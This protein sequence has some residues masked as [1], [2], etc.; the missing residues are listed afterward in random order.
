[1]RR[2]PLLR[3]SW[4]SQRSDLV[5]DLF[6]GGGGASTGIARALGRPVD[7]AINHDGAALAMHAANHPE[8]RHYQEDIWA[9]D[10]R[11][12]CGSRRVAVLWASPDCTSHSRAK[13]KKPR[14]QGKRVL[15]D[16][17]LRWAREV[18]PRRIFL[19]N[20]EEW[21][22]W[23]PLDAEGYP[24]KAQEGE[25]FRAWLA[26]LIDLGYGV[27]FRTLVAADYGAPTT[28]KRLYLVATLDG[29]PIVWSGASHGRGLT[30]W[31]PA[32]DIIDWSL[33]CPS[34]FLTTAE[35]RALGVHR[36][37]A[38]A[39]LRR[40]ATGIRRYVVEAAEPFLVPLRH[41]GDD[42]AYS[43]RAPL[44]T[45]TAA[46][47][48]ELACVSPFLVRHGHYSTVTGAGLDEGCGAGTFRGQPL[49]EPLATVCA[50]NDKH[51]V[52]P[53]MIK[54][55][56]GVVG[57]RVDDRPLGAVTARDHHSLAAASLLKLY[58]TSTG[59]PMQLPL[60]TVT[61]GGGKGGGHL[62]EVRAFL[63]KYYGGTKGPAQGQQ[64]RLPL[65]TA[66]TRDR[67]GLGIV[68]LLGEPWEI[69]DVGM[70]MLRPRELFDAQGFP[71]D[72]VIDPPFKGKPMTITEQVAKA[73]NSVSPPVAQ[74]LI[75]SNV[76]LGAA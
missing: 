30:P 19:E 7:I 21:L 5:I 31:R 57:H 32:S 20:V 6:A 67:F 18:A 50:T 11:E 64:L 24:I 65:G 58:G 59:A 75:T 62:A 44:V 34:I 9:V 60:P 10:P 71:R 68:W 45:V 3:A 26:A 13:G 1:M 37:L 39:T 12:V 69:V 48:G 61:S 53:V 46:N 63:L 52:A 41:Q 51:V 38:E 17:V 14:E 47:R 27:E 76:L 16:A 54:H 28:R 2:P 70:R 33:P 74:A 73:G 25:M 23:G 66:T 29:S 4:E 36:P 8:T 42:R 56:G 43:A 40:I 35:G 15:A 55:Y 49:R 22:K 72:Y